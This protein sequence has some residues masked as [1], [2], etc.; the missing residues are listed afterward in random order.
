MTYI[1]EKE[2]LKQHQL[3]DKESNE[4]EKEDRL[5]ITEIKDEHSTLKDKINDSSELPQSLSYDELLF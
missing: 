1:E 4:N 2:E 3:N 5:E